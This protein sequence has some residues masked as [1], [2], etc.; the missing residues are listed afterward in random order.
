MSSKTIRYS[1]VASITAHEIRKV[2]PAALESDTRMS[3]W[4]GP[5]THHT[6][7]TDGNNDWPQEN[8]VNNSCHSR[9]THQH[10]K[11]HAMDRVI[12][13]CSRGPCRIAEICPPPA[14]SCL[15]CLHGSW[16]YWSLADT[17]CWTAPKV[18]ET[19]PHAPNETI[20][21]AV[22]AF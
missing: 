2:E 22:K 16:H 19:T 14:L 18:L 13:T 12:F 11:H 17:S 10:F 4:N 15:Q 5:G 7:P 6:T 3:R 1:Q 9:D 8:S 21:K 20:S